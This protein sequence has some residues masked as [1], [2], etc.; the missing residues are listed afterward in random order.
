MIARMRV[1]RCCFVESMSR[2]KSFLS[3]RQH[4]GGKEGTCKAEEAGWRYNHK[5]P[6]DV[7]IF[8]TMMTIIIKGAQWKMTKSSN[9]TVLGGAV[10][11]DSLRA[12]R[13]LTTHG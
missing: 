3:Q 7:S 5:S 10:P 1:S 12:A 6:V 11:A 13:C 2:V 9:D 8:V 4:R